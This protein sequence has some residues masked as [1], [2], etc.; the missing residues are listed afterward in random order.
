MGYRCG[1]KTSL[2]VILDVFAG[3]RSV[4]S[5]GETAP[6]PKAQLS[7]LDMEGTRRSTRKL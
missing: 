1:H 3:E 7:A 6:M 4:A 2:W 5:H